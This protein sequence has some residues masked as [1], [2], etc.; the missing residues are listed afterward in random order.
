MTE[1]K[2]SYWPDLIFFSEKTQTHAKNIKTTVKN[3][4]H[5]NKII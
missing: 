4:I 1:Y 2:D 3:R 5:I